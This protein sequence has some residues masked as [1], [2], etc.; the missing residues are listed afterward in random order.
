MN[1]VFSAL[2]AN[3]IWPMRDRLSREEGLE[4]V[5]YAL[6]AALL[7]VVIIAAVTLLGGDGTTGLGGIFQR[8]VDILDNPEPALG[9]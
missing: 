5:E 2:Y 7:S 9:G 4:A 6:V 3:I 8:I 1:T